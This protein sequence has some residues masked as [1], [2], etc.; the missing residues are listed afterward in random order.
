MDNYNLAQVLEERELRSDLIQTTIKEMG[1]PLIELSLNTPGP[2]KNSL[3]YE[4]AFL[5]MVHDVQQELIREGMSPLIIHYA[6][7]QVAPF[8]LLVINDPKIHLDPEYGD[9][10]S[11]RIKESMMRLEDGQPLGRLYDIDVFTSDGSKLSR[12]WDRQRRCLI[13]DQPANVCR[14]E[15]SH[16]IEELTDHIDS[17]LMSH[18]SPAL[19]EETLCAR[20]L[21]QLAQKALLTEVLLTPK[22]G[23]VDRENSGAHE[24]MHLGTFISTTAA[25]GETFRSIAETG[26]LSPL[27][28]RE[29][30]AEVF[31][32][33]RRIG[34]D[35]ERAMFEA[36]G[37][38]NTQKGA[39]FS[40]GLILGGVSLHLAEKRDLGNL[41]RTNREGIICDESEFP[42]IRR[43]IKEMCKGLVARELSSK[44]V[45]TEIPSTYGER[46]HHALG[47]SGARGEAESGFPTAFAAYERLRSYMDDE[48]SPYHRDLELSSLQVLLE[49][50]VRLEDTNILGRNGCDALALMRNAVRSYLDCGGVAEDIG[51]VKLRALGDLFEKHRIS[52]GGAADNV[53]AA[54]FLYYLTHK[55]DWYQ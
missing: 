34:L 8:A 45:S 16:T 27:T 17:L 20:S 4:I 33:F 15:Q 12:G 2:R 53:A 41:D 35:G 1:G 25:L 32:E 3:A 38:V 49:I 51:F 23:L 31:E 39:I 13:C 42:A 54:L 55:R 24:D 22:P 48:G 10:I 50:M 30:P 40:L 43:I 6:N 37:G 44:I 21:G 28:E 36:S 7:A 5:H 29:R 18:G 47:V 19:S 14:R 9:D 52:A 11:H 46:L 26:L